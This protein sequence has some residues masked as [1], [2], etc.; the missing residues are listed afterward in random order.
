M[1]KCTVLWC[2]A[3]I[4]LCSVTF[5]EFILHAPPFQ[6]VQMYSKF[7]Q[8]GVLDGNY[9]R[10]NICNAYMWEK[11]N[12]TLTKNK[13]EVQK[14][15]LPIGFI[16]KDMHFFSYHIADLALQIFSQTASLSHGLLVAV[17]RKTMPTASSLT[18]GL[19]VRILWG[20]GLLFLSLSAK[21]TSYILKAHWKQSRSSYPY[22]AIRL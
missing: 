4:S 9:I 12:E 6:T 8:E 5:F 14:V 21:R 10:L 1:G 17:W 3:H 19:L 15:R 22:C 13:R 20:T 7:R 18:R 16:F 2:K 11:E